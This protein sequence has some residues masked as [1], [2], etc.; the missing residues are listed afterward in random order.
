MIKAIHELLGPGD[1]THP[2][3]RGGFLVSFPEISDEPWDI[4]NSGWHWDGHPHIYSESQPSLRLF[5]FYSQVMSKG[6]GTLI[7]AGSHRLLMPFFDSLQ[8]HLAHQKQ[9]TLKRRFAKSHPWFAELTGAIP[10]K[11]NRIQRFMEE[12]TVINDIPVHVV[13]LTGGP[14]DAVFCH[15]AIFH[16]TSYNRGEVPRFMRVC[17]ISG[18]RTC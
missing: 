15:R 1:W 17:G 11:G 12:T 5:T 10:S 3:G 2:G 13:E 6:G 14:G 9:R 16:A 8:P 7:V 4:I 18:S